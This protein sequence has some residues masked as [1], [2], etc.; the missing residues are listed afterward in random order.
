M[1]IIGKKHKYLIF[2]FD[3]RI[4]FGEPLEIFN[5][6]DIRDFTQLG[7]RKHDN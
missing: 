5:K 4:S 7:T 1:I 6:A 3:I 2:E